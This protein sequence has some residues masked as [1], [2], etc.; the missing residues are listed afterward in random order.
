MKSLFRLLAYVKNYKPLIV[1]HVLSN[2]LT[3]FFSIFSIPALKPFLDLLFGQEA[4]I[5]EKP[6]WEWSAE[7]IQ[8]N[9]NYIFSQFIESNGKEQAMIYACVF[10]VIIFFFKNLFRYLALAFMT[11]VR[12]GIVRD[13][14]A[15]LFSKTMHLPL[16]YFS[17]TKK[18]DLMSRITADVQEVEWSVLSVLETA[19]R[20]PLM[21]FGALGA[22]LMISPKLTGFVFIL[23]V[24]MGLII[25]GLGKV[26]RKQSST[27]QKTLG[28]LV[29]KVEEGLSGLRIIK[30]FGGQQYQIEQFQRTNNTYRKWINRLLWRTDLSSPLSEFL[31]VMTFSFLIWFGFKEVNN[32]QLEVSTFFAF[33]YAFFLVLEPSKRLSKA[34][35]KIQKGMAAIDRVDDILDTINPIQEQENALSIQDFEQNITYQNVTFAYD[36]QEN[37]ALNGVDLSIPKGQSVA[38]VGTSGAGKSTFIDLLPRFYDPQAGQI[39]IDGVDVKE[40]KINDLRGLMSVVS[41]EAILFNDTIY[42]NIVF[43][44]KAVTEAQVI[45][46]AKIAN[47]HEFILEQEFGYQTNIGDRGMKLSGGQRQRLTIARAILRNPP[48]LILDEATSALDS[49]SEKLVQEALL[50]VMQNRTTIVV[51]HRLSTIQHADQIVVMKHGEVLEKGT[52]SELLEQ[53]GEY[54]KLVELQ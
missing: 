44:M 52:H 39:K 34:V 14:R 11:P 38:L 2:I 35:Y 46:A 21:L 33:F 6:N 3:V 32:N 28:T 9:V 17:E 54:K 13:I 4:S 48:I 43:G 27:A 40:F 7:A 30:A 25:G 41:Q 51:A 49:E 20:E 16:S 47:A 29:S 12:S 18:G 5:L 45:E 26:L 15:K 8:A 24:V 23:I 22:M 10:I 19:V 42:N 1:G 37:P 31:G 36:G 50:K 53:G